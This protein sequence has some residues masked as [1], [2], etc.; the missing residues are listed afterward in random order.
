MSLVC[1]T[2]IYPSL[3]GKPEAGWKT[4]S[5]LARQ[6]LQLRLSVIGDHAHEGTGVAL[7]RRHAII[8]RLA[9]TNWV[10]RRCH[11]ILRI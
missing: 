9:L 5:E 1:V 3:K 4:E 2:N 6:A 11:L 10:S 8:S 7:G